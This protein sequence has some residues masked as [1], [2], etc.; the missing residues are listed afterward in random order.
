MAKALQR[1]REELATTGTKHRLVR[2][3]GA[4]PSTES[5]AYI[6]TTATNASS[7]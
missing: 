1:A 6:D 4:F 2:L 5:I 3:A 7:V